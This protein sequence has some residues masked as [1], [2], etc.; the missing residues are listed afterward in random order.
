M[1]LI[2]FYKFILQKVNSNIEN[3]FI[4][5]QSCEGP[6]FNESD[7]PRI[8]KKIGFKYCMEFLAGAMLLKNCLNQEIS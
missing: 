2:N 5:F 6:T 4:V 3:N 1:T 8:S 7:L